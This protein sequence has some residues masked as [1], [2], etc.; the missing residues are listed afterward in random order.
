M[1]L[2]DLGFNNDISVTIFF[3]KIRSIIL[4]LFKKTCKFGVFFPE[5]VEEQFSSWFLYKYPSPPQTIHPCWLDATR[6]LNVTRDPGRHRLLFHQGYALEVLN[7]SQPSIPP[8][9]KLLFV[10]RLFCLKRGAIIG[11]RR[12]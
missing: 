7:T 8:V 12:A 5:E 3:L 9:W 2:K 6:A 1:K 10:S 11:F 4:S